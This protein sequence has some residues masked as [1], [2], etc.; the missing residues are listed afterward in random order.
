VG[1]EHIDDILWDI[2]QA[3]AAQAL[4]GLTPT[5]P[6]LEGALE[7]AREY[8]LAHPE[9]TVVAVL[10]T[11][12]TPT[13]C[14]PES[15]DDSVTQVTEIAAAGLEGSPSVRT[16]VFGVFA[17]DDGFGLNSSNRIARAGGTEQAVVIDTSADVGQ[18]F[19]DAL[20][21]VQTS[22]LDCEFQIPQSDSQL[23]Y[24]QVNLSFNDGTT[25]DQLSYVANAA[26]CDGTTNSWH[27]DVDPR[28]AGSRPTRIEVCP[29]VC[30]RFQ[31]ATEGDIQLQLGCAT[32][33]R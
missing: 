11:D 32:I 16:V 19:L 13:E 25:R 18:Q 20:R 8:A 2:D 6:A 14:G 22:T 5:G 27:Y 7:H 12:G 1:L 31:R 3:L 24:F 4:E 28:Q 21:A 9:K 15:Q 30:D 23:N 33:L 10:A 29:D 17:P 26:A